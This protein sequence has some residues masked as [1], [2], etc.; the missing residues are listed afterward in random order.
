MFK[1][2]R[3]RE[4]TVCL[5]VSILFHMCLRK[6]EGERRLSVCI[7][8]ASHVFKE[9]RRREKTVRL[10]VSILFHVFFKEERERERED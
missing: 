2:E 4:K 7:D 6:R 3:R 9:E 5:S 1:E 8:S 10:S